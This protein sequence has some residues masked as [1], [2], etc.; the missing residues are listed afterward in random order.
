MPPEYPLYVYNIQLC[1]PPSSHQHYYEQHICDI[2]LFIFATLL[3]CIITNLTL[4]A[5]YLKVYIYLMFS[6]YILLVLDNI[7]IQINT[8]FSKLSNFYNNNYF[9]NII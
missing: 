3:L 9:M 4:H 7:K 5:Q 8:T 6:K 2:Y 1:V